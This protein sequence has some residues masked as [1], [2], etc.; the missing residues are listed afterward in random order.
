MLTIALDRF[1][2]DLVEDW[3]PFLSKQFIESDLDEKAKL[4][5]IVAV[6]NIAERGIEYFISSRYLF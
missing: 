4:A 6:A 1:K 3:L 2:D 5:A